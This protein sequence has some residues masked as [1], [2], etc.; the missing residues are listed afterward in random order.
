MA[1]KSGGKSPT[2]TPKSKSP[3]KKD[4]TNDSPSPKASPRTKT[5]CDVSR[6]LRDLCATWHELVQKWNSLNSLAFNTANNLMNLQLQK[7]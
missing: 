3:R 1:S 2:K 5:T 6:R 7:Q 4:Q